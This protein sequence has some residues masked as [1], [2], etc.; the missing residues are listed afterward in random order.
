MY[1][2]PF[3]FVR[4]ASANLMK[5]SIAQHL[6]AV[7]L[8]RQGSTAGDLKEEGVEVDIDFYITGVS[9]LLKLVQV[10]FMKF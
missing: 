4:K 1:D 8:R 10:N 5:Y 9:A 7:G 6:E 3:R 2:T